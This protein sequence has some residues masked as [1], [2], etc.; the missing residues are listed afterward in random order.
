MGNVA[1]SLGRWVRALNQ[2]PGPERDANVN[3][4]SGDVADAWAAPA[5]SRD[6]DDDLAVTLLGMIE[7]RASLPR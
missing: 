6:G 1:R 2:K 5:C 3:A 4:A 7:R